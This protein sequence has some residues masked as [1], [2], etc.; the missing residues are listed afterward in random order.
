M[1]G[2]TQSI[3]FGSP[4]HGSRALSDVIMRLFNSPAESMGHGEV[5]T[6]RPGTEIRC[7][8]RYVLKF[9]RDQSFDR[10]LA[11]RW[12]QQHGDR[13]RRFGVAHPDKHW[14]I[15]ESDDKWI[16]ANLTPR[17]RPLHLYM[18]DSADPDD[19]VSALEKVMEA[20]LGLAANHGF[21]LDEGLSNF[22][23]DSQNRVYYLDDEYYHWTGFLTLIQAFKL[24]FS[25]FSWLDESLSARLGGCF[26]TLLLGHFQ[27]RHLLRTVAEELRNVNL[28]QKAQSDSFAT[29]LDAVSRGLSPTG[30]QAPRNTERRC[31][32]FAVLADVHANL[33]ALSAVMNDMSSLDI[34][35]A[36]VLGDIVGYGPYPAECIDVLSQERFSVIKGNHDH[37][38]ANASFDKGFSSYA[39]WVA[40]WTCGQLDS[41]ARRWLDELPLYVEG[42]GWL[43]VHGAPCDRYYFYGYVYQ[44][45]YEKNLEV[46]RNR[47]IPV[48]FHGHT[49]MPGIYFSRRGAD[50][51][52][53]LDAETSV[54]GYDA[55]LICPGSVG[56]PRNGCTAAQYAIFDP[57]TLSLVYRRVEYEMERTVAAMRGHGFPGPLIDR[58]EA[59]R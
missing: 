36:V 19:C 56:Q 47:R 29:F 46:L 11:V 51:F 44:M 48:C 38:I 33:P 57:D 23:L 14:F 26:R 1:S 30:I 8:E 59:G 42:E 18:A 6:G 45:T 27:D 55:S 28:P 2:D 52:R 22:G 20:A 10:D 7:D 50:G 5:F 37:G 35:D 4:P 40:E 24:W 58:L 12:A 43:G 54:H 21:G 16:V 49:H 15:L 31:R 17:L 41:D 25:A 39:R 9:R 34:K 13:E 32:R 3:V 53:A